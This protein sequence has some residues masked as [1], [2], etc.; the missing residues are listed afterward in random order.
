MEL[1][2]VWFVLIAVL[3]IGYFVLEGFDFGV[4]MLLPVAGQGRHRAPRPDQHD[5]PGLGR[6]RGLA[7]RR[8]RRD[9][10][11]V[12]RVVRHA[13]LRLLPAAAADPGRADRPRR[14]LRVPRQARRR[15]LA[16]PLGP[17][18]HRRLASCRPLLWGVAFANI[19]RGVPIDADKEYVGGVL[20]PAQPLRAARRRDDAAAVP[21]PRRDV[22]RAQDRRR[23]PAPRPAP[24][25]CRSGLGAAV[26]AVAFLVL[27]QA[28]RPAS[29]ASAVAFVAGRRRP[30]SPALAAIRAGREGWAF[31][32]TFV[33]IALGVAG[34][35]LA[36][37]PRRDADLA[38]RRRVSLTTTNAAATPYTLR[39]MTVVAVDLHP[40]RPRSTRAG[41][42]GCSASGS[43]STTSP[44]P[45]RRAPAA[46]RMRP[47]DP[48][49]RRQPGARPRASCWPSWPRGL[50]AR[51][52]R[53][54]AGLGRHRPRARRAPRRRDRRRAGGRCRL[55]PCWRAAWSGWWATWLAARPPRPV[56][57]SLRRQLRR[58]RG[59]RPRARGATGEVAVLVTRGVGAAEPYLTRYLPAL[60]LAAVLP[61]LTVVVDRDPGPAQRASSCWPRCR[62]SRSSA[63]SSASRPVTGPGEQWRAMASLSG[64]FVD[65][66]RGLPTLVAHRRA[67]AQSGRI[68]AITDR[69]R[70]ASLR[71]LR[72]AFASSAGPRAGRHAV[73]RAGRG[74]RRRPA[75]RRAR[76]TCTPRSS[77]CS[78]RPRPTGRCAGSARSSTPPPRASPRSRR[79]HDA[80]RTQAGC[81]GPRRRRRRRAR[82]W[83]STA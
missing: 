75:R 58:G 66:V 48:R 28:R 56:G 52:A 73:G 9:V 30:R 55:R 80:A 23:D 79:S 54:R 11:R 27:D 51:A 62:S 29:V 65:V 36:P 20:Q 34:L 40:D 24:W 21:D 6:Q 5:R 44:S 49:L 57:T 22:P 32:G 77:S 39:I 61:P 46:G 35:F 2:T 19:V 31:L 1:T 14:R 53:H 74:H 25:R 78:S 72:I 4:G 33:A 64:H 68:A 81:G 63:P 16:A 71:T 10:R 69:Y 18:D 8:R 3:W 59:P 42:T 45:R 50:V 60:V 7:A 26:V 43:R 82:P 70:V 76:S 17:R 12:P 41:P 13:V 83:C 67:R 38:G 37:V 15:P 47:S